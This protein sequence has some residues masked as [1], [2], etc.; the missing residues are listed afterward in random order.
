[1]SSS[2]TSDLLYALLKQ[3]FK[4]MV[5]FFSQQ[6]LLFIL[7]FKGQSLKK[8]EKAIVRALRTLTSPWPQLAPTQVLGQQ[9]G[10]GER[11]FYSISSIFDKRF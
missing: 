4:L 3:N 7:N 1:M 5:L 6:I 2:N 8:G 11:H 10:S 9:R